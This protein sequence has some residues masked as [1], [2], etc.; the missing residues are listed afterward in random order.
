ALDDWFRNRAGQDQR[1]NV[2]QVTVAIDAKLGI[3]GFYSLSTLSIVSRD[4]PDKLA[5]KL[6]RYG[7]IPA[8]L[9]GRLARDVRV[10]G[11]D[12]GEQLMTD[13]IDR[14]L[15]I[16]REV[17]V[18]A[19]VVDA[20]DDWAIDFYRTFGFQPFPSHFKRLFLPVATAHTAQIDSQS[21]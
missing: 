11:Q 17:G 1:R 15:T 12:V 5:R 16:S 18:Y 14:I 8:I 7:E 2:A 10:R 21:K 3:V 19:I 13:A 6:P 4:L 20:K 9:I